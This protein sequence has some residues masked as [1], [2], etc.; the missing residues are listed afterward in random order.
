MSSITSLEVHFVKKRKK[1]FETEVDKILWSPRSAAE[2]FY[3]MRLAVKIF[4]G[5]KV[6]I[7][8]SE[9][10]LMLATELPYT[11]KALKVLLSSKK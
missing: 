7:F 8:F 5:E 3:R 11:I 10:L 4:F 2:F 1:L 9:L 6:L